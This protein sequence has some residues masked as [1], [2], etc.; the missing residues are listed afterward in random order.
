VSGSSIR[1]EEDGELQAAI[2][3]WLAARARWSF[4]LLLLF[5]QNTSEV[6]TLIAVRDDTLTS[7][8]H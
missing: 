3:V 4:L 7:M 5:I 6:A 1:C 8:P 2:R